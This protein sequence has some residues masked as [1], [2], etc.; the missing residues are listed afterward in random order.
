MAD[1]L[2]LVS[3]QTSLSVASQAKDTL[4]QLGLTA[5]VHLGSAHSTPDHILSLVSE[6][7]ANNTK[8]FI[9]IDGAA[10][11][12]AGAVAGT[13]CRPVIGVPATSGAMGGVDALY[14]TVNMPA[15]MPVATVSVG[16]DGGTNAAILAAQILATNND[17]L[18]QRIE[19]YRHAQRN[20]LLQ[21]DQALQASLQSAAVETPAA[22]AN[23]P[24]TDSASTP[25]PEEATA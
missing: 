11:H 8:V 5:D 25:T 17:E 23:T 9:C 18:N 7:E 4:G 2:I 10:A 13:T 16:P 24:N 6:A 14:S 22:K 3:D 12:L 15:G 1:A 19:D 21:A 20:A